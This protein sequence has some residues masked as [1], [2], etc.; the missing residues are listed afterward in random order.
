MIEPYLRTLKANLNSAKE[1]EQFTRSPASSLVFC[2]V[3]CAYT[4]MRF[5]STLE[6]APTV[7]YAYL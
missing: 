5:P 6:S 3:L 4:L 2:F 7:T 1:K